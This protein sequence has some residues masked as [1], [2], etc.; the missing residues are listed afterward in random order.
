MSSAA[1]TS[2]NELPKT[3]YASESFWLIVLVIVVGNLAGTMGAVDQ[4]CKIPLQN[5]LKNT[6]HT[7]REEMARFFFLA[8]LFFYLQPLA[9][10]LTDAFPLFGTRRRYYLLLSSVFAAG[11][12]IA[13]GLV[14]KTY[15]SL[16]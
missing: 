16:L 9:G 12:W 15:A 2:E 5:I 3:S 10:I 11:A 7:S 4:L 8:G 6:L 1:T 13:L 14:P